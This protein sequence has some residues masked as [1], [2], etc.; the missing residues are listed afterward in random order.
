MRID[1]RKDKTMKNNNSPLK[2]LLKF[3]T[4]NRALL[5]TSAIFVIFGIALIALSAFAGE[6]MGDEEYFISIASCS[7]GMSFVFLF[8]TFSFLVWNCRFFYSCPA[9]E[10]IITKTI[11]K[12]SLFVAIAA[13]ILCV[14]LTAVSIGTGITDGNRISD[15]LICL[16]YSAFV[17]QIAAGMIGAR[18]TI[19]ITYGGALPFMISSMISDNASP[20]VKHI[21]ENGFGV[22]VQISAI[23]L[24]VSIAAG[25]IISLILAKRI[26]KKRSTAR[27]NVAAQAAR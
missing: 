19:L 27:M 22:P 5:V 2:L 24:V 1:T 21:L 25:Y 10:E 15:L 13:S 17:C 4:V 14:V 23:I 7:M 20:A 3:I 6:P 8:G 11:P 12:I 26:Y 16:S 9:A 18:M